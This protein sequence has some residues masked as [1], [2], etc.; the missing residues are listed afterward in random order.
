MQRIRHESTTPLDQIP[1]QHHLGRLLTSDLQISIPILV[2]TAIVLLVFKYWYRLWINVVKNRL[3]ASQQKEEKREEK[4]IECKQKENDDEKKKVENEEKEGK[5]QKEEIERKK[6]ED[7]VKENENEESEKKCKL[8]EEKEQ[9]REEVERKIEEPQRYEEE[10]DKEECKRQDD[11]KNVDEKERKQHEE[12]SARKKSEEEE[13]NEERRNVE[14][15]R[16][17]AA[18]EILSSEKHYNE[19]L[20]LIISKFLEPIEKKPLLTTAQVKE[21][22]AN[23][24]A[25][26]KC[27]CSLLENIEDRMKTWNSTTTKLGDVF[28]QYA[29]LFPEC[30]IEYTNNYEHAQR[31]LYKLRSE[32]KELN[33]FISEQ[34]KARELRLLTL[35]SFLLMPVKRIPRYVLLI[36]ELLRHTWKV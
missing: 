18:F 12:E 25:I 34:E 22:F 17:L 6:S 26:F 10:N 1:D 21:V 4:E 35:E 2:I 14:E 36:S 28:C 31:R 15:K 29:E 33:L 8:K 9:K 23:L 5:K 19:D 32:N 27:S 7:E 11:E 24:E 16:T 30:Y 20:I 13:D 3:P